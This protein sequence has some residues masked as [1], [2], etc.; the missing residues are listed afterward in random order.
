MGIHAAPLPGACHSCGGQSHNDRLSDL[1]DK[2]IADNLE[3]ERQALKKFEALDVT[4]FPE[5]EKLNH[6]LMVRSLRE[7]IERALGLSGISQRFQL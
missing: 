1:S 2:A 7:D 5:E 6:A 4:G 3:H